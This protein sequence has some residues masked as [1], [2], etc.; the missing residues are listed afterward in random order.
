MR[1]FALEMLEFKTCQKL[2]EKMINKR[3][4]ASE[5]TVENYLQGVKL[6]TKFL[7]KNKLI[8]NLNPDLALRK[9]ENGE[10]DGIEAIDEFIDWALQKR[11]NKTVRTFFY[12][13][14][15][16]LEANN[17]KLNFDEIELPVTGRIAVQETDRAPTREEIEIMLQYGSILDRALILFL[18][19]SGLRVSTALSLNWGDIDFT[20]FEDI[21]KVTVPIKRRMKGLKI[22][23]RVNNSHFVTFLTQEAKEALLEWKKHLER[24]GVKIKP[25]TPLFCYLRGGKIIRYTNRAIGKRYRRLLKRC[26]LAVKSVKWHELHLHTLRKYFA[27][28]CEIAGVNPSIKDYFMGHV[29]GYL[30]TSY[31]RPNLKQ[32]AEEYRKAIPHL[33]IVKIMESRRLNHLEEENKLL[34]QKLEQ[35]EMKISFLEQVLSKDWCPGILPG[36]NKKEK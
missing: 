23:A 35:L 33:S 9:I 16:W 10:I 7:V 6:F 22:G 15:K 12:G 3:K 24:K 18:T 17:V 32:L 4:M 8:K 36:K 2:A 25:D 19:A 11:A 29:A 26:G 14:R 21:A 28:M 5:I 13:I 31:F 27:T 34:K 30:A 20:S 1:R